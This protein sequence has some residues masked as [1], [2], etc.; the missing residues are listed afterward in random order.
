[1]NRK[2]LILVSI[3][4]VIVLFFLVKPNKKSTEGNAKKA[5]FPK[6]AVGARELYDQA[7]RL[8]N[9][10]DVTEAKKVYQEILLNYPDMENID[11]IQ[12][13]LED[14]N[15]NIILSNT[16]VAGRT[17]VHEVVPGDTLGKI[18]KKYGT[19]IELIKGNNNLRSDIIRVGQ[20]LRVWMGKFN[21]LIDKSQNRLILKDGN[22][23]V[24]SYIISTGENNAT[25]VGKF[26]IT[27]KLIDP[28][29]FNRGVVVPPESPENVL[30]TRWLGFDLPGYGIHGTIEPETIG[31]QVTA[32]CIRMLNEDVEELYR[33]LIMGTEVVIID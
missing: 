12:Q 7:T 23:V 24:K 2:T 4:A 18:A 30:G 17:A 10:H 15:L 32:G 9:G 20:K 25:P 28:V 6:I 14:L 11:T 31:K 5:N 19:T 33:I 8:K 26:K 29:W 3:S 13:E 16:P 22:E 21:V 1:M 27:S